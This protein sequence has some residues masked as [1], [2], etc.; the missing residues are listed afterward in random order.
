MAKKDATENLPVNVEDL[1]KKQLD[2]QR[3]QLGAL[4]SNKIGLNVRKY[5]GKINIDR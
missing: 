4:P 3:G 5:N 1:I 2:A